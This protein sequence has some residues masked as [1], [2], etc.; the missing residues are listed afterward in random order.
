MDDKYQ[1]WRD[2]QQSS[3]SWMYKKILA[4]VVRR[5]RETLLF[6]VKCGELGCDDGGKKAREALKFLDEHY[7]E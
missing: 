5:V 7:L 3:D 2:Q 4:M 6:Y 1:Q